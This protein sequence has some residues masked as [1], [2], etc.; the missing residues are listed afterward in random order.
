M[1]VPV[2]PE[3]RVLV[4]EDNPVNFKLICRILERQG[5]SVVAVCD[6]DDAVHDF[7]AKPV[8]AAELRETLSR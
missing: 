4:A 1:Q 6:G 3:I 8:R 7:L 2:R 5:S